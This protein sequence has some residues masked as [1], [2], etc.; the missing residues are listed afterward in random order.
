M[1]VTSLQAAPAAG[2]PLPDPGASVPRHTGVRR[3]ASI[4]EGVVYWGILALGVTLPFV[5]A[6]YGLLRS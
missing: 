6:L 5:G 3:V 2:F 4:V 1:N